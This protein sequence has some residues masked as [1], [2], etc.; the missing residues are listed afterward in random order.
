MAKSQ[1]FIVPNPTTR[2]L[3]FTVPNGA[4]GIWTGVS[5]TAKITTDATVGTRLYACRAKDAQGN[6]FAE[7]TAAQTQ[8]AS[9][10]YVHSW[11]TNMSI[12]PP[13]ASGSTAVLHMCMP[14]I[15]LERD[16]TIEIFDIADVA[17]GDRI[18]ECVIVMEPI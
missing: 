15:T 4:T 17:L 14:T 7:W 6:V 13:S 8:T 11:Q 5:I 9:Q 10:E 2:D 3:S 12:Q 18:T 16:D 1:R